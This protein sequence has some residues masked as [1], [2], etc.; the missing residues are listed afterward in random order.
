M[1]PAGS[2]GIGEG[3]ADDVLKVRVHVGY[4]S[5]AD[6]QRKAPQERVSQMLTPQPMA[7][8]WQWALGN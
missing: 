3:L 8:A 1:I 7:Q 5:A 2:L 4:E 6:G